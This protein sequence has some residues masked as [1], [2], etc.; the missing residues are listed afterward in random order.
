MIVPDSLLDNRRT[1]GFAT[2]M[3]ALEKLF[4]P[5][6]L[7]ALKACGRHFA[8]A[9]LFSFGANV[10]YLAM[11]IYMLQVY[12]RVLA[13]GSV[14]TLVMLTLALLIALATL[15]ALEYLR[16]RI[17]SMAGIR[18]EKQLA[19]RVM[20]ALVERANQRP[21]VERGQAL[22]DLD[23]FRH[24]VAGGIQ[25]LFD[26]PWAPIFIAVGFLI[27]W[28]VGVFAI[29]CA[30]ALVLMALLNQYVT[31]VPLAAAG[32][33]A[34]RNSEFS[35]ATLRNAEVIQAMGMHEDLVGRWNV[36]RREVMGHQLTAADRNAAITSAIKFLRLFM[37]SLMLGLGA[38]LAI[39]RSITPGQMFAATILLGRSLQ[40]IEQAVSTWRQMVST[41]SATVRIGR[42]L[43]QTK[44]REQT[45]SLPRPA[46]TLAIEQVTYMPAGAARPILRSVNCQVNVGEALAIIGP[47][48]AGKSTLARLIVGIHQP[49]AGVV[50]LDGANV[51]TWGR[52]EF[53]KYTG[54]LP[55]DI[56]LFAGSVAENIAR[57][58]SGS[59]DDIIAAATF[60]DAHEMI[61]RL[62]NGYETQVGE[63]G[64]MLSAGQRQ[65]VA[66]ARSLYG[67]PS[68]VV[69]DEPNSN[70]DTDGDRALSNAIA[71]LKDAGTTVVIVTHRSE[72]LRV[73]DKVLALRDGTMIAF[74]PTSEVM[75]RLSR[76][77]AAAVNS[78]NERN[79][80][81]AS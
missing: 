27:H 12:D 69:L 1:G 43:A 74:G 10:L 44:P 25:V 60:A 53:G 20:T 48:A 7:A 55:Q 32:D 54:Y 13:S 45:L 30:V 16:S 59:A 56:E 50:R 42:L 21:G 79:L 46:G 68:L 64:V 40:P 3:L 9:A 76:L 22:R 14:P 58:G 66:L 31:R 71:K 18:M 78:Q 37:Q 72:V 2:S 36:Q 73:V 75:S 28:V 41:F 33:S 61:L 77:S 81:S 24:F 23:Q 26:L 62:P 65:R 17:L 51:F 49:S 38:Y 4:E 5:E 11:P 57:F 19:T 29:G 34:M 52:Q 47:T 15:V 8:Y 70:L 6:F 39:E 63:S 35:E 80:Q 67:K